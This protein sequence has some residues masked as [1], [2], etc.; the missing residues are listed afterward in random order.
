[1]EHYTIRCSGLNDVIIMDGKIL[2]K[3]ETELIA[4]QVV[5]AV[6]NIIGGTALNLLAHEKDRIYD[7]LVDIM[8]TKTPARQSFSLWKKMAHAWVDGEKLQYWDISR[9]ATQKEWLSLDSDYFEEY[10]DGNI[11]YRIDGKFMDIP[12]DDAKYPGYDSSANWQ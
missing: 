12:G 11:V 3:S 6:N 1:M 9:N 4:E 5:D 8:R 10:G 7:T 2:N